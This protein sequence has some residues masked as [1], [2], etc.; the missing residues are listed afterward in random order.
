MRAGPAVL[1]L[2]GAVAGAGCGTE[3]PV[4]RARE[5]MPS[6]P[7]AS[8][9]HWPAFRG[10]AA[11]GVAD[12][13]GLPDTWSGETGENVEWKVALPGLAHSS[14]IVHGDRLFV[15]SAISSRADATFRHGIF[16]D[17]DASDDRSPHRF[18][19]YA[20]DRRTGAI[21]W[22][23]TAREGVPRD[24]RHVKATYANATPVTDGRHVVAFFG[25]EGV[26]AW[27]VE[28]EPLWTRD[29]GRLN[30]GAYDAPEY[31]WGPASSPILHGSLVI[32][33]CDTQNESFVTALD[34]ESGATI[35]RTERVELPSWATPTVVP[36]PGRDELVTNAPNFIRG[37]DPATGEELWRLG[38]SSRIT[39]PTPVFG[40]GLIVVASGRAPE[41]PI[42]A[43]RPGATGDITLQPWE[44]SNEF[45]AW[46]KTRRG[47]YMPTPLI[48][49]DSLYV[50]SNSGILDAYELATGR[51]IYRERLRHA[52]GGF[53]ASPVA[54]DG[55]LYLAAEDGDVFV[56]RAG[57]QFELLTRNPMG[58]LL[59]A[60]PA[61]GG[62]RLYVRGEHHVFAIGGGSAS[63]AAPGT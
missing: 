33:Q 23:R 49:R 36:G 44:T 4:E 27:T 19:I 46:S 62:G 57:P 7:P 48:Y 39:A 9:P 43:I 42:F 3:E 21:L 28:G 37:Y 30:L 38:G 47:P 35:W 50:L 1:L 8:A 10:P 16:G 14:P 61:L 56:V 15:T 54:A 22:E 18:V 63:R 31:E 25:S 59:M 17:G 40:E 58:E 45:V 53:S 12:G 2:A 20:L 52:G 32:L 34:V 55:K 6:G 11:T 26:F 29:L 13:Q 24:R 51:E 41:R 60:T 5:A